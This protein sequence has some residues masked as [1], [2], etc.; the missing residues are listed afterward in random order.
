MAK[1]NFTLPNKPAIK[2]GSILSYNYTD[3]FTFVPAPLTFNRDS[4][5]TRVNEKGLIEDVGYF[6]PEL[7]QNG[8][9]SEIGSEEIVNGDFSSTDISMIIGAGTRSVVNGQLKIEEN[10]LAYSQVIYNGILDASKTY[11]ATFDITL[12]TGFYD[13]YDTT[14]GNIVSITS[15]GSYT[16]YLKSTNRFYVGSNGVGD[17]WYMDNVS[18]KEVG[19]NWDFTDGATI[20]DNG[21]R[22]VSDGTYQRA[23][24]YNILTVGKNYKVQYEIVENNSGNL[25]MSS[26]FGITAIPSTVGTHII[27]GQALQTFLTIERSG[28]CDVTIDNISVIEVLGDKP[29]IDYSDSLTEPSL[30]LEP[31]RTNIVPVSEGLPQGTSAVTLT[32][33]YGTSPEGVQNSLKVQKN[34]LSGNDRIFPI[35]NYNAVLVNGRDYTISAF[36]KNIDVA[37]GGVTTIACR[38]FGGTL[39]RLGYEWNGAGLT[40][41]AQYGS[42][43][44]VNEIL[45]DYGNGWWRI[46]FG[47]EADDTT[48]NMEVDVDR[49]NGSDTTSI[50]TWGWQFESATVD[51]S[52]ATSYIPTAGSTATRL[53]ETANNAGDVN[54]FNGKEG[55]L[56]AEI[57]PIAVKTESGYLALLGTDTS[58]RIILGFPANSN[59][60]TY[61]VISQGVLLAQSSYDIGDMNKYIKVAL[62]YSEDSFAV[63]LNGSKILT[64]TSGVPNVQIT[65]FG[66]YGYIT[67]QPFYGKVKN[68]KA[69][70]KALTDRELEI[71]TIQ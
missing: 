68:V 59:D 28:A 58:N 18:V 23:T 24:Q 48:G 26:S 71:L 1:P 6:G 40:K 2:S 20:T 33:N 34:G 32:E 19:Q 11:K 63:W 3:D 17:V 27:N 21:V 31:Q 50:E 70:N 65:H 8:D 29:R 41:S 4:A 61:F 51:A 56:Y 64:D 52:Y 5:A 9:F 60:I 67:N 30:L 36:V 10:G 45:E 62:K 42:G 39:F 54:V 37:N 55:V 15:S 53:G 14:Q 25:K 43:T 69:F 57:N 7:V 35:S 12:G 44:R 38:V 47:F 22:I 13:I 16:F 49:L 66:F 46:G